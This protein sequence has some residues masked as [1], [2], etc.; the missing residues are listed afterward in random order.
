MLAP[1]VTS[2]GTVG[3]PPLAYATEACPLTMTQNGNRVTGRICERDV[4]FSF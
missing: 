1:A 4:G 2:T 3:N